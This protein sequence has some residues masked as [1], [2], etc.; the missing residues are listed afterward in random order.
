[1]QRSNARVR[2][3]ALHIRDSVKVDLEVAWV[4][5]DTR[6]ATWAFCSKTDAA[7]GHVVVN[8]RFVVSAYD[9]DAKFL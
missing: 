3:C 7:G 5:R 2:L 8:K 4:V 1:M 6:V 9:D